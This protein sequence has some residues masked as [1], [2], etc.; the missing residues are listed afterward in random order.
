M[1]WSPCSQLEHG[2][3]SLSVLR[4]YNVVWGA[5]CAS[6]VEGEAARMQCSWVAAALSNSAGLPGPAAQQPAQ[7]QAAAPHALEA[8]RNVTQQTLVTAPPGPLPTHMPLCVKWQRLPQLMICL[9]W[10]AWPGHGA[11]R[12]GKLQR[13]DSADRCHSNVWWVFHL[14]GLFAV[15]DTWPLLICMVAGHVACLRCLAADRQAACAA[16]P[17]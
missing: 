1:K 2:T 7:Q 15:A 4:W 5:G 14:L 6:F 13:H 17:S 3:K 12:S 10:G 11:P 9:S 16:L 8:C